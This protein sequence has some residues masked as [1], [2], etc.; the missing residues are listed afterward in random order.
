MAAKLRKIQEI[1]RSGACW[2]ITSK[3]KS[4][5]LHLISTPC[6]NGVVRGEPLWVLVHISHL[7]I[8]FW[9]LIMWLGGLL[10]LSGAQR[11]EIL[12]FVVHHGFF[13][14]VLFFLLCLKILFLCID[15][16]FLF[17]FLPHLEACRI[18]VPLPGIETMPPTVKAQ[19]SNHRTT[20]EVPQE[21]ILVAGPGSGTSHC[22]I[23]AIRPRWV[24]MLCEVSGDF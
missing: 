18:L 24:R 13:F 16:Y 21:K 19:S 22:A 4:N 17:I 9:L 8:L 3:V 7:R 20:R 5:L 12:F 6:K 2:G 14:C 23:L 10:I 1:Q 15:F 11:K